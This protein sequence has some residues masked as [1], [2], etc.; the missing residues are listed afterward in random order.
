MKKI[1]TILTSL[2]LSLMVFV[3]GVSALNKKVLTMTAEVTGSNVAVNGT[4]EDGMLAVAVSV[5][6]ADG[7]TLVTVESASVTSN[8]F[9]HTLTL[10]DGTYIIRVADYDGGDFIG[11]TV[12]VGDGEA[13]A[14]GSTV[15]SPDTGY[16]TN[17]KAEAEDG[18][19]AS[20]IAVA[21][22]VAAAFGVLAIFG[23]RLVKNKE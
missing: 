13:E 1:A 10:T 19:V 11:Q 12:V 5:Y 6:K 2:V 9:T 4:T 17:E 8:A 3:P 22:V 23:R 7:T 15:G 21:A 18:S 20:S 16:K 14:E